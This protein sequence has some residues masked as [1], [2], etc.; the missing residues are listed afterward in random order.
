MCLRPLKIMIDQREISAPCRKCTKCMKERK[1]AWIGRM[2]AAEQTA[3]ETW[4]CTFTYGGGYENEAAYLLN[5]RDLQNC[6]KK[7]RKAGHK[8]QYVSVGEYGEVG[9]RAHF[10]AIIYWQ[11][12]PPERPLGVR[13]NTPKE[14]R[15][16]HLCKFWDHGIV[17]YELPKSQQ[18]ASV[19]MMD[20]LDKDNLEKNALKYSKNPAL[21]Q[22]YLLEYARDRARAGLAL[23]P[24]GPSF[25]IPGNGNRDGK[26]FFY[27]LDTNSALYEK[28]MQAFLDEW[29]ALRPDQ[30]MALSEDLIDF[31]SEVVQ[32]TTKQPIVVQEYLVRHYGYEPVHLPSE[33]YTVHALNDA[34]TIQNRDNIAMVYN[35]EGERIWLGAVQDVGRLPKALTH[36]QGHEISLAILRA[37][38]PRVLKM[39]R[40][41]SRNSSKLAELLLC[42]QTQQPIEPVNRFAG[43][44]RKPPPQ[45][46]LR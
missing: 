17:Q 24:D 18:G 3:V 5:Y 26:P 44:S 27:R 9:E 33:E 7:M 14:T 31:M 39:L 43:V 16:S 42:V 38:P 11:S 35:E 34:M 36:Q 21:G 30:K 8:F 40:I 23:F 4:F 13:L 45:L 19:Y 32:N 1:M 12:T 46:G 37:V 22:N 2:L 6:F 20:Y 25:T 15:E 41:R 10:H 28:M 29:T